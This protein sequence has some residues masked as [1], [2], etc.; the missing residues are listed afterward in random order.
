[1]LN[2]QHAQLEEYTSLLQTCELVP[3]AYRTPSL[4]PSLEES[5]EY[6]K[7][8]AETHYENFHVATWFLPKRLRPHFQSI[9]AYCRIADDLG[10]EIGDPKI[11]LQLLDE[12]DRMLQ[13]CY[14]APRNSKHPVFIALAETVR[15]CRIPREPF[16]DLL[17]AFRRDQAVT[18]CESM[19]QLME[20]SRYSAN[21]VG[22]LVLYA[23]GY[24]DPEL[25]K[26]SDQICTALQLA[27]FWQDVSED[28]QNGRLYLPADVMQRHGVT[29]EQ[30]AAGEC[31]P[32][33]RQMMRELVAHTQ[34]MFVEGAAI[35]R[36]VD[37]EL[38]A[39]LDLFRQGGTATLQAIE[40]QKYDVLRKRP[41][42]SKLRKASLLMVALAGKLSAGIAM[43]RKT[44]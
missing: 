35:S 4:R 24:S 2:P 44:A 29:E 9:Y 10:D 3:A 12:W 21:P 31:T 30:I 20:Y 42:V 25:Q 43:K 27:N 23:C 18:R 26:L 13:E 15:E 41:V 5:K 14:D 40:Q 16:L 19:Q 11:S 33:F 36:K 34:Q 37:A 6:C 28:Y 1:M 39:T 7:H 17:V 8:L 38:A 32:Q 22:R